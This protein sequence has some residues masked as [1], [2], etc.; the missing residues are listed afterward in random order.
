MA[1]HESQSGPAD[2]HGYGSEA[3]QDFWDSEGLITEVQPHAYDVV[4][5]GL[6]PAAEYV[7]TA[8]SPLGAFA[9]R[10]STL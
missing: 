10:Q 8:D 4:P 1:Y 5:R 9:V 3:W 2:S 6:Q 7:R